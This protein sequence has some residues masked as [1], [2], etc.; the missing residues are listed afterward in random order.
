MSQ[1]VAYYN[2][3][4][5][6]FMDETLNVDMSA[7]Y[8][9][10][11]PHLSENAHILDAGCGSGRDVREF[12]ARDYRVTAFDASEKLAGLASA[13][14]GHPVAVRTFDEV[15]ET[16][17]YDGV[18]ACASLLHLPQQQIPQALAALW[19][20]LKPGGVLYVS[21][22]RGEGQR[23]HNGRHFTDATEEQLKSWA[24][25]LQ[26]LEKIAIW[27]IVDWG[28]SWVNGIL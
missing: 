23:E 7:L 6:Q 20:A 15:N 26:E 28:A 24:G 9:A 21:F 14:I 22:K 13:A 16:K 4:A 17:A 18:W 11:L 10:F 19:Q 12:L 1:S 2:E 8:D 25:N 3:H 27:E 5:Q